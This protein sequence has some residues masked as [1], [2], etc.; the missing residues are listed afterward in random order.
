V[1]EHWSI[2][3]MHKLMMLSAAYQMSSD[4]SVA[5]EGKDPGNRLVWR[6]NVR[7]LDFE[8][9]RD[10]LV[11]L[12][13]QM[14][15]TMGGKPV[16]L[17]D[18]PFSYRRSIYGYVD[19]RHLS[20][21]L[22]QFDFSDPEM[23]NTKRISTIV[24]QQALFFMNSPMTVDVARHV[25]DRAE[26]EEANSDDERVAAIYRVL[27]QRKP[28]ARE[29]LWAR[30]YIARINLLDPG[31]KASVTDTVVARK[32]RKK[33]GPKKMGMKDKYAVIQNQGQAVARGALTPWESY[34]Q[35]LLC[36]NEFAYIY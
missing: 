34:T 5:N 33:E 29:I 31:R 7:R 27:F 3:K 21:L 24:P 25:M 20:D 1:E 14:D 11:E 23:P 8:A 17:T 12:T 9:I 15:R 26:V 19:R 28:Q 35:A 18:E 2:K 6:A 16:N 36:S 4:N 13:G 22:S 30:D 10:S 32:A